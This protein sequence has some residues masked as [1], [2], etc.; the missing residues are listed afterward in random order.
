V[1]ELAGSIHKK[2]EQIEID[3][4]KTEIFEKM[5]IHIMRFTNLMVRNNIEKVLREILDELKRR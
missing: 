1:V 2:K 3:K 4:E 5:E